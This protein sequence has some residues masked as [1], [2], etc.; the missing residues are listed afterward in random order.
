MAE[1]IVLPLVPSPL[2]P[3]LLQD[4]SKTSNPM[5]MSTQWPHYSSFTSENS[6]NLLSLLSFMTVSAV[7]QSVS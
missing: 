7:Q 2:P 3:P 1:H 5:R 6:Q 4:P